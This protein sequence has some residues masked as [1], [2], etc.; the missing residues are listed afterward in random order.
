MKVKL[1]KSWVYVSERISIIGFDVLIIILMSQYSNQL[2]SSHLGQLLNFWWV[3][4]VVFVNMFALVI[5]DVENFNDKITVLNYLL[6][7]IIMLKYTL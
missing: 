7:M 4:V 5:R 3:T 1:K 2:A 6:V